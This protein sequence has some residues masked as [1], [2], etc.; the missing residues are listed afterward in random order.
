MLILAPG[1]VLNVE[2]PANTYI[3]DILVLTFSKRPA[4]SVYLSQESPYVYLIGE[5]LY[6]KDS[7]NVI[8]Q[9]INHFMFEIIAADGNEPPGTFSVSTFI[10]YE[11][12]H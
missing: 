6:L 9:S 12:F 3:G 8:L 2:S 4:R 1:L 7:G 11:Y 10:N 5:K